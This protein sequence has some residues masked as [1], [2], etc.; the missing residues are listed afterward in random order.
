MAALISL[1]LVVL[2]VVMIIPG[3]K[4]AETILSC[5]NFAASG[6][7]TVLFGNSED[8]GISHP[9]KKDP[10]I[11]HLFF[12]P[13]TENEFG[14]VFVGWLW[15]GEAGS[16]QGG[17]N[18]RGLSYDLTG[19]PDTEMA[20]HPD[21]PYRRHR[22]WVL[23]EVLRKNATVK[24]VIVYLSDVNWE[25]HVWFQWFFAD[26]SGDMVIV[27][28]DRDG[29]LAF[30]RKPAGTDGFMTQTNFN[31]ANPKSHDGP[32]PCPRYEVS[33]PRRRFL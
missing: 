6:G 28:P 17:M 26:A 20:N 22:D 14:A 10:L 5:T 33:E 19:I 16:I 27:S 13:A 24:E 31:R 21:K 12:Y 2:F 32:Y 3:C 4:S 15:Q 1:A 11:A 18:D 23:Y 30:T 25:G 8:G 29:E 7:E 9:L